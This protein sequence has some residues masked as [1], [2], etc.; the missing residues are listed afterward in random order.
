VSRGFQIST[1]LFADNPAEGNGSSEVRRDTRD[2]AA[3]VFVADAAT[4]IQILIGIP[5]K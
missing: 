1:F 5:H 4:G 3:S 2:G